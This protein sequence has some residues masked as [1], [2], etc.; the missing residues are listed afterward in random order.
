[1]KLHFSDTFSKELIQLFQ[2]RHIDG[3]GIHLYEEAVLDIINTSVE[4]LPG[5]FEFVVEQAHGECDFVDVE[6]KEKYDAKIP[7]ISEQVKL[8]TS[9]KEHLPKI[10]EWFAE[11]ID[12]AAEYSEVLNGGALQEVAKTKL[13][14]IMKNLIEADS[15]GENIIFFFPFPVV[16]SVRGSIALQFATDY[17]SAIYGRLFEEIDLSSRAIF[18]IYPAIEKN[19]FAL[20][21]LVRHGIEFIRYDKLEK[22]FS[23]EITKIG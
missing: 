8:L 16:I 13:Y 18:A 2:G 22:W 1:M 7:L 20:R 12:E 6:S 3:K 15:E 9:E 11:L 21:N 19:M 23:H 17:L 10:D 4:V 5:T 14:G